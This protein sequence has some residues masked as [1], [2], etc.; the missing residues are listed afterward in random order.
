MLKALRTARNLVAVVVLAGLTGLL[1]AWLGTIT[2]QPAYAATYGQELAA[3]EAVWA[4]HAV[5]D[6]PGYTNEALWQKD[7]HHAWHLATE[8]D[9]ELEHAIHHYLW[10]DKGW[11]RVNWLCGFATN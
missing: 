10:T 9:P 7:W 2:A 11:A 3:C 6:G 4:Y 5:D 1:V 8:A